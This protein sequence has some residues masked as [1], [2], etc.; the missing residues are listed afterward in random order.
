MSLFP[1]GVRKAESSDV[2]TVVGPEAYF[3]GAVTVRGSLRVEGELEGTVS[4]AQTVIVGRNGSIKGDVCADFVVIGGAVHGD[5]VAS[6]QI[7]LK[8][9]GRLVGNIRTPKLTIEEGAV[10]EGGCAMLPPASEAADEPEREKEK[11]EGG[12]TS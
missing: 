3:H 6:A 8:A 2:L 5:V 10:F 11:E 12:V 9:G 7:E 4:E 1:K